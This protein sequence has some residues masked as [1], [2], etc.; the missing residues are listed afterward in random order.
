MALALDGAD[1]KRGDRA[2]IYPVADL[3]RQASHWRMSKAH[4]RAPGTLLAALR[5]RWPKNVAALDEASVGAWIDELVPLPGNPAQRHVSGIV[6]RV[7]VAMGIGSF[8]G[9]SLEVATDRV[10]QALAV[11][12]RLRGAR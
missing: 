3:V 2:I 11:R 8:S 1:A 4:E 10:K 7:L 9:V 12:K 5:I 6:A